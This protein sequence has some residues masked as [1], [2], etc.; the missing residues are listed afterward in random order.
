MI[1]GTVMAVCTSPKKGTQKTNIGTAQFIEQ[2]GLKE[3]AHGGDWHRQVSLLSFDKIEDFRAEGAIVGDGDFG[4]NLVVSGIDFRR[5][6]IGTRLFCNNVEL[7][8]TQI[9]KECHQHCQIF[10]KMGKCIM[11]TEGVFARVIKGGT[12]S[13]GDEMQCSK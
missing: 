6:P 5:L 9:G 13:Q 4:E 3:D 8:I 11:P 2:W 10:D 7:E 12:I 1:K